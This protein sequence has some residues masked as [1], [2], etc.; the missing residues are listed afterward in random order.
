MQEKKGLVNPEASEVAKKREDEAAATAEAEAEELQQ[1]YEHSERL[2]EIEEK[3]GGE[4]CEGFQLFNMLCRKIPEILEMLRFGAPENLSGQERVQQ[5]KRVRKFK[6]T[7]E[8][9]VQKHFA[10]QSPEWKKKMASTWLS[11]VPPEKKTR[12]EAALRHLKIIDSKDP[13]A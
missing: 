12:A 4:E 11:I 2:R 10:S 5:E 1:H 6:E 3:P 7:F 9:R 13:K 8:S